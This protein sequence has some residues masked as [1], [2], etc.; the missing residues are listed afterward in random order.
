MPSP[1]FKKKLIGSM[2]KPSPTLPIEDFGK[3][4]D[5]TSKGTG[6]LGVI[7]L[8]NG[9]VATEYTSQSQSVLVDG[10]QIDFPTLVPTLTKKEI[11][12]MKKIMAAGKDAPGPVMQK[13]VDHALKQLAEGKSVFMQPKTIA[14]RINEAIKIKPFYKR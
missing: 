9:N 7:D 6:W 3:R 4:N 11:E 2:P 5:G 12:E 10:K 14:D 8:G 1:I 13:A